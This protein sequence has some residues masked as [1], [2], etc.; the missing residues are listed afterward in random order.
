MVDSLIGLWAESRW[1]LDKKFEVK[2]QRLK[3]KGLRSVALSEL[4]P[5]FYF[6]FPCA[7]IL[8]P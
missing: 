4:F 6:L 1:H 2:G 8:D 5:L 3:V 7:L